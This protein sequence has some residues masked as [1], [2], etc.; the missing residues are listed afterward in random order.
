MLDASASLLD[1][2]NPPGNRLEALRGDRKGQ[3][4]IRV[5]DQYRVCFRWSEGNAELPFALVIPQTEED[6]TG[7]LKFAK[8]HDLRV[9]PTGGRHSTFVP[10]TNRTICLDLSKFDSISVD[11]TAKT[12]TVGGGALTGALTVSAEASP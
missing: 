2:R 1:L 3:H 5:N 9:I 6:I 8:E 7:A 12:V 4:S 11:K 10:I